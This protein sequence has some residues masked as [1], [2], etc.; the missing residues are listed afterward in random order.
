MLK[1][2][3]FP[4]VNGNCNAAFCNNFIDLSAFIENSSKW[5]LGTASSNLAVFPAFH[6]SVV[7]TG[8]P[9]TWRAPDGDSAGRP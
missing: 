3:E 7:P 2:V 6:S 9:K 4:A 5:R 8:G 1:E